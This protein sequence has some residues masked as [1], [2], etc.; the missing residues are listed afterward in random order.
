VSVEDSLEVMRRINHSWNERDWETFERLHAEDVFV[1]STVPEGITGNT[2]QREEVQNFL[3][4]F[5]DD[6]IQFPHKLLFRQGDFIC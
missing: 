5:R 1:V 3:A 4:A 6:Q 2:S